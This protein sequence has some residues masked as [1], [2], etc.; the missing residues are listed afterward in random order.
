M[1]GNGFKSP[2]EGAR[3]EFEAREGDKRPEATSVAPVAT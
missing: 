3:V 1:T 2:T